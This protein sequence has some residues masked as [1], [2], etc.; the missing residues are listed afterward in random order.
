MIKCKMFNS[1][2]GQT[3]VFAMIIILVL[4]VYLP[5]LIRLLRQETKMTVKHAR[6]TTAFHLAEAA[7]DR[8]LWKLRE[9][10]DVWDSFA[11][12]SVTGYNND[13]TY[14]DIEGGTYKIAISTTSEDTER[15]IIGRGRDSSTN[16]VRVIELIVKNVAVEAAISAPTINM[17]GSIEVHWGPIK[18]IGNITA[19]PQ[20][21]FPRKYAGGDIIGRTPPDT[22]D[23]E[24]WA[25]DSSVKSPS[26]INFPYYI[27]RATTTGTYWAGDHDIKTPNAIEDTHGDEPTVY[28]IVGNCELK[29]SYLVGTLIVRGNLYLNGSGKGTYYADIPENAEDEYQKDIV[30]PPLQSAKDYWTNNFASPANSD[31][32]QYEFTPAKVAVEGFIYVGGTISAN[33][34]PV[35]NGCIQAIG[36]AGGMGGTSIYYNEDIALQVE[37]TEL[38]IK[39]VSWRELGPSW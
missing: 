18:S 28:Y 25:Y 23:T 10:K 15:K 11:T 31:Y 27:A 16:E 4:L 36:A 29:S 35:I 37:T 8:G 33:G 2:K 17:G 14:D 9:S 26:G 19:D 30:V 24:Y 1:R 34:S 6:S 13:V 22:D 7:A 3:L 5:T 38:N 39:Q 21:C 32:P 20:D 12:E